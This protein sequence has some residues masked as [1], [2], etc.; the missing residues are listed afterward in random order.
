MIDHSQPLYI[1]IYIYKHVS[2]N[3]EDKFGLY[4]LFKIL[5][6]YLISVLVSGWNS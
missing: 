4:D 2:L 3:N 6:S 1:Y 5:S